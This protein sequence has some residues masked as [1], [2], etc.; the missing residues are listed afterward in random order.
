M[1]TGEVSS[2]L[3]L[4]MYID[5]LMSSTVM[6]IINKTIARLN[7]TLTKVLCRKYTNPCNTFTQIR[8]IHLHKS[9]HYIYTMIKVCFI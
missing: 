2:L 9:V 7:L 1:V 6:Y 4:Y 3:D 8:A 5:Q